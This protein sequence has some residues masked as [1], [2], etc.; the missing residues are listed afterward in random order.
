MGLVFLPRS[1]STM[2]DGHVSVT[3]SLLPSLLL[4]LLVPLPVLLTNPSL[5]DTDN[6][7]RK[8]QTNVRNIPDAKPLLLQSKLIG[9]LDRHPESLLRMFHSNPLPSEEVKLSKRSSN[10]WKKRNGGAKCMFNSLSFNC[11][12]MDAIGAA[13]EASYWGNNSPGK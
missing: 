12:F 10:F 4:V 6:V 13:S 9:A 1:K 8:R 2:V 5:L 11:D 3:P 7:P